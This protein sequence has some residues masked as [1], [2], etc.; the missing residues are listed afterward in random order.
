MKEL[1]QQM[2]RYKEKEMKAILLI[3]RLGKQ[4]LILIIHDKYIFYTNDEKKKFE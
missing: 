2:V 1:K 3:L 4:E